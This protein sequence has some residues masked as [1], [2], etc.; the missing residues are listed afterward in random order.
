MTLCLGIEGT[1][2]SFGA[3]VVSSDG[4]VLS[5]IWDMLQPKEGGIHPREASQHHADLGPKIIKDALESAGIGMQDIGERALLSR[6]TAGVYKKSVI[7]ALP[8]SPNG[9][10]TGVKLLCKILGHTL[11]LLY[12]D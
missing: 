6:A 9:V 1:A 2:H 5:N 4:E 7:V 8:G 11:N 10:V 3:G 12:R